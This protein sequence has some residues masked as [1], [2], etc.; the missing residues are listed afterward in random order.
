MIPL[1]RNFK[2]SFH[3]GSQGSR[4]VRPRT[5]AT[6]ATKAR[7]PARTARKRMGKL[8]G[9]RAPSSQWPPDDHYH[10][11]GH[12]EP[13]HYAFELPL[14]RSS[15]PQRHPLIARDWSAIQQMVDGYQ[16]CRHISVIPIMQATGE[17]HEHLAQLNRT[18]ISKCP[19]LFAADSRTFWFL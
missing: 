1:T 6:A 4:S 7:M 14:L 10:D 8:F 3:N 5:W 19:R 16:G 17:G 15:F 13:E 9:S 12:A 2:N 18:L 11:S